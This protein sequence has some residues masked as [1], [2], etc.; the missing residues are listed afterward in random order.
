MSDILQNLLKFDPQNASLLVWLSCAGVW[1]LVLSVLLIDVWQGEGG[2][3]GRLFWML[4]L[5]GIPIGGAMLY[6][7][8]E[9][10]G[11]DWSMA[12]G[13]FRGKAIKESGRRTRTAAR[14]TKSKASK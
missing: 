14:L 6:A 2:I 13:L 4:I 10:C 1:L 11:G 3:A 5:I 12:S 7:F 8:I 9:L